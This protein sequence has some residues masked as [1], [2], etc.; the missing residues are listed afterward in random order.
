[1][2][3]LIFKLKNVTAEEADEVRQLLATNNI[4]IYET[5][6]GL[7]G[8]SVAGYWLHDIEQKPIAQ[9]LLADYAQQRQQRV[10]QA[11]IEQEQLGKIE[12]FWQRFKAQPVRI[13]LS[14]LAVTIILAISIIPFFIIGF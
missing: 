5:D 10:R 8:T 3:N 2:S 12:T 14:L 7:F 11:Y 9:N 4:S 6:S 13:G 1:M